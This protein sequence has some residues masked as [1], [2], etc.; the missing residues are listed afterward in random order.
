MAPKSW[1]KTQKQK[2]EKGP[3][4]VDASFMDRWWNFKFLLLHC[5]MITHTHLGPV[6]VTEPGE[7]RK[8]QQA[9][10]WSEQQAAATRSLTMNR[11][12]TLLHPSWLL[13]L[14]PENF[15]QHDQWRGWRTHSRSTVG[16]CDC[17]D[18][19]R[20]PQSV[21]HSHQPTCYILNPLAFLLML[22]HMCS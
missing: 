21:T 4:V 13:L 11:H 3:D 19:W 20:D 8:L 6:S 2:K 17:G 22:L 1:R 16:V 7:Q 12:S 18:E 9:E 14:R 5:H 15:I 10:L